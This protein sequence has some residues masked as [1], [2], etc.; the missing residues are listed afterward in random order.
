M[1]MTPARTYRNHNHLGQWGY[2]YDQEKKVML[3]GYSADG[4]SFTH[5]FTVHQVEKKDV[6]FA[7]TLCSLLYGKK[8]EVETSFPELVGR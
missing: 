6:V 1:R 5:T 3:G 8:R 4:K 2:T 7:I